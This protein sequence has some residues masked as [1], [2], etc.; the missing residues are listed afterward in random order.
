MN[1][2]STDEKRALDLMKKDNFRGISKE[3]VMQLVSILDKVDPDVAK[4]IISQMPEVIRGVVENERAYTGVLEKGIE[5]YNTST[6]SCF[7]TENEIIKTLQ[8]EIDKEE[9][10]FEQK[11]YYFNKMAEAAVRK[12]G[13]DTE[14]KNMV[15]TILKYGGE[16]ISIGLMITAGIF[17]GKAD[18]KLPVK[19]KA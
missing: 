2:L 7:Q 12:E 15:Q 19:M 13:K 17:I 10:T 6:I 11:Q 16:A 8:K 3:N 9:T 4:T 1:N 18:F 14:H 5:S